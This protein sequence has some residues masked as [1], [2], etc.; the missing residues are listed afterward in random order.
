MSLSTRLLI[1]FLFV[2]I[3]SPVLSA[4]QPPRPGTQVPQSYQSASSNAER[5]DYL[6]YLPVDYGQDKS[7]WPLVIF[8]HGSGERGHDL[9]KVKTHGPP[10]IVETEGFPFILVSPQCPPDVRWREEPVFPAL[11]GLLREIK[12]RYSVDPDR[13][14]LTGLSMGGQG[15]WFW[16]SQQFIPKL[17]TIRGLRLIEISQCMTGY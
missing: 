16:A 5:L 11:Q 12:H 2:L 4:Q 10:K 7:Q 6:L 14:Y 8:L 9:A 1:V 15:T 3:A 17:S 13:I